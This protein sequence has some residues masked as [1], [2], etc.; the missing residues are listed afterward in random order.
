ML[1][2]SGRAGHDPTPDAEVSAPNPAAEEEDYRHRMWT[3]LAG[4]TFAAILAAIGIWLAISIADMRKAQDCVLAG[5][6]NCAP[7]AAPNS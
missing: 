3:N 1:A 2:R 4:F 7:I 5:H 6:R